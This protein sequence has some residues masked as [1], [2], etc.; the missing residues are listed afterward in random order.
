MAL[1]GMVEP[2]AQDGLET[3]GIGSRLRLLISPLDWEPRTWRSEVTRSLKTLVDADAGACLMWHKERVESSV[4]ELEP[5]ILTEY[6]DHFASI[7]L[8]MRRRDALG[9][10]LWSRQLLWPNDTLL[11]STYYNEFARPRRLYDVV[12]LS[13]DFDEIAA[14][15]RIVLIFR[16]RALGPAASE[17][18]LVRLQPFLPT[19]RAGL[20]IQL[21][22]HLWLRHTASL[23]DKVGERLMLF[24]LEGRELH[25]NAS[26]RRTL[27]QDPCRDRLLHGLQTAARAIAASLRA[28]RPVTMG[29]VRHVGPARQDVQT[30]TGQ[31]R[32]RACLIGPDIVGPDTV[33]L[34]TMD[35][36]TQDPPAPD[37]L[38]SRYELTPREIQVAGMLLQRLTN[39]EIAGALGISAH[40]ARHHTES[41]LLKLGVNS[42]RALRRALAN[43]Q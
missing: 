16:H 35:R 41:V 31:Y 4:D 14:H 26:M 30:P 12:G 23:L 22:F 20:R 33:V 19:L 8:G 9:L 11:R 1:A 34:V 18:R 2:I 7:D 10:G 42:R 27:D 25:R 5:G 29:Q 13:I 43:E 24:S 39:R 3:T 15:L 17:D 6:L 21:G 28:G 38:Q 36:V 40:T 37:L 32:L